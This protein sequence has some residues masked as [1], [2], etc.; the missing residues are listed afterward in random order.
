[1]RAGPYAELDDVIYPCVSVDKP[2]LRLLAFGPEPP[3]PGW[4]QEPWDRWSHLVDRSAV[5]RL[6]WVHTTA[7][8][9]RWK[10][11]VDRVKGDVVT[12]TYYGLGL[13]TDNP[14]IGRRGQ[15]EWQGQVHP[16]ELSDVVETVE[17]YTV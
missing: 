13:P 2:Y 12:F 14:K 9:E 7:V 8:W 17:E 1:V 3:A 16:S 4:E 11:D 5:T 10:V 15:L 6:F